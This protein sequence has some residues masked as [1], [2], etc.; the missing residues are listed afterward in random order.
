MI[1]CRDGAKVSGK[2]C[3][4]GTEP[5]RDGREPCGDEVESCRDETEPCG[6][7]IEPGKCHSEEEIEK[8]LQRWRKVLREQ[9][10]VLQR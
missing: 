4:D 2:Y 1:Y 3:E 5:C 9:L 7:Q 8:V 10:E 6:N